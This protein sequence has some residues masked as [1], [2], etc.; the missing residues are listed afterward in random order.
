MRPLVF[1]VLLDELRVAE[2][3]RLGGAVLGRVHH[4]LIITVVQAPLASW[5]HRITLSRVR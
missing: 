2:A 5:E 4:S 1:V 3:G